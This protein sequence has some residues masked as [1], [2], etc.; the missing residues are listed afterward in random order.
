MP[1]IG[2]EEFWMSV[3]GVDIFKRAKWCLLPIMEF[4]PH[5]LRFCLITIEKHHCC[6]LST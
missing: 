1:M 2:T 4:G 5:S 6:T 3:C